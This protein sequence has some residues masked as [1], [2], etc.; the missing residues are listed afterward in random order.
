MKF[1]PERVANVIRRVVSDAIA[2]KLS[3]PR[4]APLASITRVEVSADLEHAK[5]HVSVVGESS[6]GRRT[7]DGLKSA[8][9]VVQ[10]LVAAELSIRTCPRL[11]FHLDESLKRAAETMQIIE[12]SMAEIT[13]DEVDHDGDEAPEGRS[14][15]QA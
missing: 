6:K 10:R 3:D 4:I 7:I 2:G 9:G 8:A 15:E 5:V 11:S 1:R 12:A 13:R 14:G